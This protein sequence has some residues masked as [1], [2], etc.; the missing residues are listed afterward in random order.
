MSWQD[1]LQALVAW[2]G[3]CVACDMATM[4]PAQL[5]SLYKFLRSSREGR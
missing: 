1:E 2:F 5:W 3:A 4:N